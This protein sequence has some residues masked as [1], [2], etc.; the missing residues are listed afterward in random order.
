M[1][2]RNRATFSSAGSARPS[3]ATP[4]LKSKSNFSRRWCS[5]R[6]LSH[7]NALSRRSHICRRQPDSSGSADNRVV[8][9][10]D[11]PVS[12]SAAVAVAATAHIPVASRNTS[13]CSI[14]AG[15]AGVGVVLEAAAAV[16]V[17]VAV[18]L[19][20]SRQ[21]TS[22][23]KHKHTKTH[24]HARIHRTDRHTIA[25]C[26]RAKSERCSGGCREASQESK[27]DRR[28]CSSHINAITHT[29]TPA[30]ER[31]PENTKRE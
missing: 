21:L 12:S 28:T 19:A 3:C 29:H 11:L 27:V 24:T 26:S 4:H 30:L 17:I 15:T 10:T 23:S 8:A 2:S 6:S 9:A 31:K 13:S 20:V 18:V 14:A 16:V 22:Q 7:M 25:Y 5:S 1:I